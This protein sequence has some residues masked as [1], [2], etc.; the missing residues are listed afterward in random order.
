MNVQQIP[1]RAFR[2]N[3]N[4]GFA[5]ANSTELLNWFITNNSGVH[6]VEAPNVEQAY[7]DACNQFVRDGWTKNPYHQPFLPKFEDVLRSPY[8]VS[9]FVTQ[10]PA[11]R[12]FATVHRDFVGIYDNSQGAVEFID[13]FAPSLLKEFSTI[14]DAKLWLNE[15]FI[16]PMLAMSAYVTD[17]IEY[18]VNIPLNTAAHIYYRQWWQQHLPAVGNLP[19]VCPQFLIAP[20]EG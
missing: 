8:H 5:L 4:D 19:F 9:G 6:V 2:V 10:I 11:C 15:K 18:I 3:Y 14:D 17:S 13:Y 16:L 1:S 20:K 7:F 12:F